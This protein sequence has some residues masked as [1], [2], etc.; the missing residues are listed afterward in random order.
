MAFSGARQEDLL[1]TKAQCSA[2]S[3]VRAAVAR[4]MSFKCVLDAMAASNGN[5]EFV[6]NVS[7]YLERFKND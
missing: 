6:E 5:D 1:L 3:A 2:A 7:E 4:G